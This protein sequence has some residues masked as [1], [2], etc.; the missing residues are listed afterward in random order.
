MDWDQTYKLLERELG[1]PPRP[2]EVQ[3][4]LQ[5][6]AFRKHLMGEE[7]SVVEVIQHSYQCCDLNMSHDDVLGCLLRF[8]K[9]FGDGLLVHQVSQIIRDSLS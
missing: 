1:R 5:R 3:N 6:E 8:S 7:L 4:R 9:T 2:D